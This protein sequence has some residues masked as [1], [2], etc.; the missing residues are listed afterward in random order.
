MA[1]RERRVVGVLAF[2]IAGASA[3][4]P[5]APSTPPTVAIAPPPYASFAQR[6]CPTGSVLTWENTGEPYVRTWCTACHTSALD[7]AHR[8]GAP[9]DVNFDSL[10]DV[11]HFQERAW[12]RAGDQNNSMPPAGFAPDDE[13][14]QFGEWLA[15]G[16]KARGE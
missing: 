2:V 7:A 4:E 6:P 1:S 8:A 10:T 13:R 12:A 9:I 5:A 14:A 15:C 3:C 11:R 16:A